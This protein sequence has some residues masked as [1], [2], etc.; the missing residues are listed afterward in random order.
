[1]GLK[2]SYWGVAAQFPFRNAHQARAARGAMQRI[3]KVRKSDQGRI[4]PPES[5]TCRLCL[6]G[7]AATGFDRLKLPHNKR[8]I[9]HRGDAQCGGPNFSA[10]IAQRQWAVC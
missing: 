5:R 3:S 8:S 2:E 7:F 1:M 10:V 4:I 9:L 6:G